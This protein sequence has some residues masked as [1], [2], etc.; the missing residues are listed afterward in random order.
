MLMNR[1]FDRIEKYAVTKGENY[2]NDRCLVVPIPE[3]DFNKNLTLC[4]EEINNEVRVCEMNRDIIKLKDR[5]TVQQLLNS[6]ESAATTTTYTAED[7]EEYRYYLENIKMESSC[8]D[9][10]EDCLNFD[11]NNN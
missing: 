8:C 10:C 11:C 9:N 4:L 2:N 6:I 5:I 7:E 1:D 3:C